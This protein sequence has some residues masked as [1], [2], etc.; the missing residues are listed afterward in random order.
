VYAQPGDPLP[1]RLTI[2]DA[3]FHHNT[4]GRGGAVA[5]DADTLTIIER[6]R[7]EANVAV[8]ANGG[9]AVSC[10]HDCAITDSV[11]VGNVA[12]TVGGALAALNPI[13]LRLS[14]NWFCD[15][16]AGADGGAVWMSGAGSVTRNVYVSNAAVRGGALFNRAQAA[17]VAN[18]DF[19]ANNASLSGT[20]A[21]G[22]TALLLENIIAAEHLGGGDLFG[23]LVS[24]NEATLWQ[25]IDPVPFDVPTSAILTA[26]PLFVRY[27]P[28]GCDDSDL[29]LLR[30]SPSID[31]S[32]SLSAPAGNP[33][34]G[35]PAAS[36]PDHVFRGCS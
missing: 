2:V 10:L 31:V 13:D 6:T 25:N 9:G 33:T 16:A 35:A 12:A 7:F 11:F 1:T 26:D 5:S 29:R 23:G 21:Y 20:A 3:W 27:L 32:A 14:G 22:E 28:D 4:A 17:I 19:L 24:V 15:N 34:N 36:H 8:G 18:S 30:E